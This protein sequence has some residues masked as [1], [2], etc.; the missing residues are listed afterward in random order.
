MLVWRRAH[1]HVSESLHE[2]CPSMIACVLRVYCPISISCSKDSL[3]NLCTF[4]ETSMFDFDIHAVP[5]R[6]EFICLQ[7]LMGQDLKLAT[8]QPWQQD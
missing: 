1:A 6:Y 2:Y 7:L 5:E 3:V 8:W 4:D